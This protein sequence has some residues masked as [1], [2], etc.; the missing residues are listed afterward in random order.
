MN[1]DE[2]Y[3]ARIMFQ[4]KILGKSG[5]EFETFFTQIMNY[6]YQDFKQIKPQGRKGDRKNDGYIPSRGAYYQVYA[7]ENPSSANTPGKAAKKAKEDFNGLIQYW[8]SLC[9]PKEY[10]FVFNDKYHGSYPEIETIMSDLKQAYNLNKCDVLTSSNLENICFS[11]SDESQIITITG[12]IPPS[13]QISLIDYHV[14]SQIIG[15]IIEKLQ[16]ISVENWEPPEFDGKITYN[17]LSNAIKS[18][19]DC[20]IYQCGSLEEYFENN[21]DFVRQDIRDRISKSYEDSVGEFADSN[22]KNK[23]DI[24]FMRIAEKLT[25]SNITNS[26]QKLVQDAVFV[27]MAYYFSS[28]DIFETPPEREE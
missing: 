10:Y 3:I 23:S 16:P 15:Y 20:A 24:I 11:L 25:P 26:S 21:S 18:I 5:S 2:R 4:N 14:L 8:K 1:I 7:P 13:N 17:N 28:C 19:L 27:L 9:E 6:A 12:S 22:I